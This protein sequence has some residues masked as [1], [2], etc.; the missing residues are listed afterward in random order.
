MS[1][2]PCVA[3]ADCWDWLTP[4]D[5]L[6]HALAAFHGALH[7][8]RPPEGEPWLVDG[9]PFA[10]RASFRDALVGLLVQRINAHAIDARVGPPEAL[11]PE[12]PPGYAWPSRQETI[13]TALLDRVGT[14]GAGRSPANKG[15]GC[16]ALA[17][18]VGPAPM[19][20]EAADITVN[21]HPLFAVRGMQRLPGETS[22]DTFDPSG[23]K[24]P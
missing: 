18:A 5:L 1:R 17:S 24:L 8:I 23:E 13:V 19:L 9:H 20:P 22:R 7:A 10:S 12:L 2:R 21:G 6:R 14:P 11:W 15:Q 3:L 16:P 4:D